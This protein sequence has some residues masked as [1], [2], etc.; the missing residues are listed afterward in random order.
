M[1]MAG[2]EKILAD[3][4]EEARSTAGTKT[5]A[6][7]RQAGQI[8][9]DARKEADAAVQQVR[10]DTARQLEDLKK[11]Q[12]SAQELAKRQ[13]ML[14]ARQDILNE[15][16]GRAK[17][18]AEALPDDKYFELCLAMA[19]SAAEKRKGE[20]RFSKKDLDRMPADFM[21]RLSAALPEG[22]ELTL[23]DKPAAISSGFVLDYGGIEEDCTF[24]AV[25][26]ERESEFR[27]ICREILFRKEA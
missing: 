4:E 20:I 24:D 10:A 22:A 3:I 17:E 6:A 2:L 16:L 7:Q 12:K 27:D 14:A 15:A 19:V 9:S 21:S 26:A 25:F 1:S 5:D 11:R 18:S 8:L 23:N 13:M